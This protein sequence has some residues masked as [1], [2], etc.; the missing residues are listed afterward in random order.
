MRATLDCLKCFA[1]QALRAARAAT[2]DEAVQRRIM[3]EVLSR[4]PDMDLAE[5]PAVLSMLCYEATARHSGNPDP[6][7]R[8]KREQNALAL[9]L[10]P[11]LRALLDAS[12][13]RLLTA[14][15]LSAAGNVIDLGILHEQHIDVRGAV[16]QVLH[17]RFAVDHS[18]AFLEALSHCH[19]L[20]FFLDNA[21]EIVF[22]KLL[23][24]ELLKYTTVTAV[25]KSAPILNDALRE[26]ADEVGLSD[27]C[28]IV[29]NG[30]AFIGAPLALLPPEMTERMARA[31]IL[32]G[33]GQG[34][35][36]TL[37]IYPGDVYLILRAK[38]EVIAAHMGVR[39][40][41]V[42]FISTRVRQHG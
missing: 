16:E 24:E 6:F 37:D 19:D 27:L 25:V 9:A 1:D 38:C 3:N 34:N 33:K 40:G 12:E 14:F 8:Q 42:G 30:G 20:L 13:D 36:E 26:D 32:L 7:Y 15:H 18:P 28:P 35:Y 4:I 21:G 11:E 5:S 2:Q 22:D 10:E 39:M 23:I 17:E 29:E 31:D 41:R